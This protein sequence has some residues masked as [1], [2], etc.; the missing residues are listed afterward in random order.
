M[1]HGG[2]LTKIAGIHGLVRVCVLQVVRSVPDK[3]VIHAI[4]LHRDFCDASIGLGWHSTN[5]RV[6]FGQRKSVPCD[7]RCQHGGGSISGGHESSA[8]EEET[9]CRL[10]FARPTVLCMIATE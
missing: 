2:E 1:F 7:L 6:R 10:C 5:F 8:Q 3:S 4:L 9:S